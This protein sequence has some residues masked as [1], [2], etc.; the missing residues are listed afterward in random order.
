M[1]SKRGMRRRRCTGKK[2]YVSPAHAAFD[3]AAVSR[4]DGGKPVEAYRCGNCGGIHVGHRPR[5]GPGSPVPGGVPSGE[6][7]R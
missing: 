2:T 6:Q 7:R 1:A 3:A 5:S 4:R